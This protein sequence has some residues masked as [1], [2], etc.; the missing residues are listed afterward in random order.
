MTLRTRIVSFRFCLLMVL[1]AATNI[2][3]NA[4]AGFTV[5]ATPS[6]LTVQQNGQGNSTI[7]TAMSGGFNA[8]ISLSAAGMP[9]G[10]TVIFNPQSIPAPGSGSSTMSITVSAST[11]TGTYPITVTGNGGG[12]QQNATVTLTVTASGG[13]GGWQRGFDF[14]NTA[15][16]VSDPAGDSP[17]LSTTAYP[18]LNNGVTFGWVRTALVQAR[19]R[20]AH[21]DPR[22]AGLNFS[23]NGTP[24]TFNVDLPAAGTYN[25]SLAMGDAGYQQCWVQCQIQL[26]DGSTVLATLT[27]GSTNLNYF[28]DAKGNNWSAAAWPSSNL[29]RQVTLTGTRLTVVVGT[30][31]LTG[32]YTPIAFLGIAQPSGHAKLCSVGSSGC[33]DGAAGQ[34]GQFDD[35]LD[36]QRRFQRSHQPV[37]GRNADG[38]DGELQSPADCSAGLRQ[39][40]DDDHGGREHA[41]GY[42]PDHGDG[43]WRRRSANRYVHADGDNPAKLQSH[44]SACISHDSA[45]QSG[46]LD[47]HVNAYRR[48]QR[49][50]HFVGSG[51]AGG[52]DGE[53]RS[54]SD[55]GAGLRQ[56]N[57]DHH[58][59]SKHG[60]GYLS[61]HGDGQWQPL[62]AQHH[63]FFDRDLVRGVGR[64]FRLPQYV[65]LCY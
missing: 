4:Q 58:G 9:S 10:A 18:T 64:R 42:V 27:T 29:T 49:S 25:V 16:Y 2:T 44:G 54:E 8:A 19:D 53:L 36:D 23:T 41:S 45:G 21:Q 24:A 5:S 46:K 56:L 63:R 30:D 50:Y 47:D 52:N 57:H 38:N 11:P 15:G 17:V 51:N 14:R 34:P 22:L 6:S 3:L 60:G 7:T 13:G 55:T 31:H 1:F 48:L 40:N 33:G 61:D 32:D 20:N 12:V 62:A 39:L 35:H 59:G 65:E 28:F 26:L 43:Q 37:G